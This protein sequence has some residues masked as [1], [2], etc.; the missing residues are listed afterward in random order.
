MQTHNTQQSVPALTVSPQ[1]IFDLGYKGRVS[2]E[3][4]LCWHYETLK[5]RNAFKRHQDG[6][7]TASFD[8]EVA[9][10]LEENDHNEII[11]ELVADP[12]SLT[13]ANLNSRLAEEV[14]EL[15]WSWVIWN[16]VR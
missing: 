1:F 12:L 5:R 7:K 3:D 14:D 4:A 16:W 10:V 9:A 15:V 11:F 2:A 6:T 13:E 8:P